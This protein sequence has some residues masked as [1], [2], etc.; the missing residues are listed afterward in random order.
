MKR[1]AKDGG[2]SSPHP[3]TTGSAVAYQSLGCRATSAAIVARRIRHAEGVHLVGMAFG[4]RMWWIRLAGLSTVGIGS[5][6]VT[7]LAFIV[8]ERFESLLRM[9]KGLKSPSASMLTGVI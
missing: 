6:H 8:Q 9:P 2:F 1:N 3:K 4:F 7:N 5:E